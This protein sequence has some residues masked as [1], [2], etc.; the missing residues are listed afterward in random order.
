M[1]PQDLLAN[2]LHGLTVPALL[3]RRAARQRFQL[4]LS[5]PSWRGHRDRL[6]YAQL[7]IR[8]EAMA[9]SLHARGLRHGDRVALL[10]AN[11]AAREGVLTALGCW[12]LGAAVAPLNV[13]ASDDELAHALA[14]VEPKMVV[15]TADA[16]GRVARLFAGAQRLLLDAPADAP[17]RWP[18]PEATFDAPVAGAPAPQPEDLSC[19]LFTSGTTARAKAVMHCHRSQLFAGFAVGGALGLTDGD[20]YQGAW[21]LF[22]SSVLNMA[23]MSAWV[24]GAGVVLEEHTLDN[25][26]RL[27]LIETEG[28]S[29][30]HGVTAP[31][32]FLIDEYPKGRYDLRGVRRLGYGGAVMPAEVI[33]KFRTRLPWVDQVHIWGMTETGPAGTALPPWYLP[34]KAGCIGAPMPGCA[35]RV[36]D[37]GGRPLP[38]GEDGE[39]VFSGP[40]MA[41]GY[42][43]NDEATAQAFAGGWV[44]TGDIGRFDDEGHL[45]FVDRKKDIINRGGL[46]I[47]SAAV[48]EVLYRCPGVAEAAV[49]AVP[50]PGLGED[51]AA[52]V[53]PRAGTTLDVGALQAACAAH[54]ADYQVPRRW[55]VLAA[56][57]KN[58]M[59]KVLKRELRDEV[60]HLSPA[61]LP[62]KRT[63]P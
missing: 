56:L 28:T 20:T 36:V 4:A 41:L 39:I 52:C 50:H 2:E 54:L 63:S 30:Y 40:S 60:L 5:A 1:N 11:T 3:R 61:P 53:V 43:R 32:H 34:R 37:D 57:P 42:F 38:A 55:H 31:L 15:T 18:D 16:A 21:P 22:T 44:R 9:R 51:I 14:L 49:V 19:L 25:A 8:M 27:R 33:E 7:V 26:G 62:P 58:P 29:V 23:C 47:A 45:H 13:R 10:V 12:A 35:V 46:K 17:E 48:E 24:H 6:S 59:G